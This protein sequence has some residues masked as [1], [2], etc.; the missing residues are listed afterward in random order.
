MEV[1]E[2]PLVTWTLVF[3]MVLFVFIFLAF[4]GLLIF[5]ILLASAFSFHFYFERAS[6]AYGWMAL[7]GKL[8]GVCC[9]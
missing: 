9:T 2:S 8:F 5:A 6:K 4:A 7:V 1:V 3:M